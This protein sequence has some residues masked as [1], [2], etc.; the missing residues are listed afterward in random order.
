[1][2]ATIGCTLA[3][4]EA[5]AACATGT[6]RLGAGIPAASPLAL[7][8]AT[9]VFGAIR[10]ELLL[11]GVARETARGRMPAWAA[12]LLAGAVAAAARFGTDG[13]QAMLLARDAVAGVAFAALWQMDRGALMPIAAHAAWAWVNGPVVHGAVAELRFAGEPADDLPSFL[14]L[15][16]AAAAAGAAALHGV[17]RAGS[18][19]GAQAE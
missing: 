12:L 11:R 5:C 1:L 9:A 7:G 2:G 10:D 14:V 19:A 6:A 8:L 3:V 4:A 16:V 15:A 18:A 13:P 17:G